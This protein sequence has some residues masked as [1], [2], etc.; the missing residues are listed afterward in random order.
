MKGKEIAWGISLDTKQPVTKGMNKDLG[1]IRLT[2]EKAL[3]YVHNHQPH[4][5]Y[6]HT[7]TQL[8]AEQHN[9]EH[10]SDWMACPQVP[11]SLLLSLSFEKKSNWSSY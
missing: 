1:F 11:G 2:P 7:Y 6:V 8:K 10:T 3:L 9:Q 4:E 5:L